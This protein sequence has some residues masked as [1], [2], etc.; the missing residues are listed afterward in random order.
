MSILT[1]SHFTCTTRT[2]NECELVM[3]SLEG[4]ITLWELPLPF[5]VA[6]NVSFIHFL[7]LIR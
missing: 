5:L 7:S 4:Y 1:W 6:N 2:T 3:Q